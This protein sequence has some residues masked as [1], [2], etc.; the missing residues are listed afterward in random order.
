MGFSGAG[1]GVGRTIGEKT[2]VWRF[3]FLSA[4]GWQYLILVR[5]TPKLRRCMTATYLGMCFVEC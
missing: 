3:L 4:A 5:D 2:F 1:K